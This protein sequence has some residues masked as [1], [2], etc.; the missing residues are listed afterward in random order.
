VP[1]AILL[2]PKTAFLGRSS[3]GAF[4]TSF[5]MKVYDYCGAARPKNQL[6]CSRPNP[7]VAHACVRYALSSSNRHSK[8][9]FEA[10]WR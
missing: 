4:R 2:T 6:S 8:L 3:N 7:P 5:G 9:L 10:N 1:S